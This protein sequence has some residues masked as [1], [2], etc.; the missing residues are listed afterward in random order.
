[1]ATYGLEDMESNFLPH[2]LLWK[3][4]VQ[5][6]SMI[7]HD[8]EVWSWTYYILGTDYRLFQIFPS[9]T[10]GKI[11]TTTWSWGASV[12][13]PRGIIN[14][15]S[16]SALGSCSY[17]PGGRLEGILFLPW[18]KRWCLRNW[19]ESACETPG[20]W[21]R[22]GDICLLHHGVGKGRGKRQRSRQWKRQRQC[23]HHRGRGQED[24]KTR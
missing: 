12:V 24:G 17:L 21:R 2:H 5:T 4:D 3:M 18:Y 15:I 22:P 8:Q 11:R 13:Q 10:P 7:C 9:R 1:M 14:V 16:G 19:R 6:W 20:S 23:N